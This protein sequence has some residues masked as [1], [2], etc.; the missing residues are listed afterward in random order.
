ME[1]INYNQLSELGLIRRINEQVL[2]PLG[3]AL[4]RNPD[5]GFSE[6]IV[7]APDGFFEYDSTKLSK[8][9]YTDCEIRHKLQCMMNGNDH[10]SLKNPTTVYVYSDGENNLFKPIENKQGK[11]K[12]RLTEKC[13]NCSDYFMLDYDEPFGHCQCGTTEWYF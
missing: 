10:Q 4:T 13:D 8:D 12:I 6:E 5:T 11:Y 1:S 3:L 7:V 9:C 2:H